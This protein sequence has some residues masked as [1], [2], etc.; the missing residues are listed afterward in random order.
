MFL[1]E[2]KEEYLKIGLECDPIDC[3][4]AKAI[5]DQFP[6]HLI[7]VTIASIEINT[8]VWTVG[9]ELKAWIKDYDNYQKVQPITIELSTDNMIV[10]ILGA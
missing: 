1:I 7:L 6:G 3:A 4:I 8:N 10:N 9:P 2:I 5:R